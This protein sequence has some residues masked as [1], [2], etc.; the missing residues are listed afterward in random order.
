MTDTTIAF[1]DLTRFTALADVHGDNFALGVIDAFVD[2]VDAAVQGRGRIAKTMGDGVLLQLHGP[3]DAVVVADEVS[4]RLHGTTGMPEL[5]AGIATGP[6]VERDGD[7]FGTTV[8]LASRLAGLAAPGEMLATAAAARAAAHAGWQVE[9]LGLTPIR[10]LH[11]PV[12]VHRVVLCPVQDCVT[13]PVCGMRITPVPA[14]PSDVVDGRRLWL[15]SPTCLERLRSAP[16]RYLG[17][18]VI[19]RG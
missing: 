4:Q 15:C 19:A 17:E 5:T 8:N 14:T 6:V 10:G 18:D 2:A 11:D 9:P 1:L 3:G 13:D 16:E 12:C 7:V